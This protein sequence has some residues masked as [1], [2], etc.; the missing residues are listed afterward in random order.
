MTQCT[1]CKEFFSGTTMFD[2]HRVGEHEHLWS[3]EHPEGRRCLSTGEMQ[4]LGWTLNPAKG[5]QD[6]LRVVASAQI[7]NRKPKKASP[8]QSR[9]PTG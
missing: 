2:R 7:A 1:V 9:V 3:L 8:R 6:P 4:D 5:W